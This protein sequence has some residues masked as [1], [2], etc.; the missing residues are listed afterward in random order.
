MTVK[1]YT[2]TPLPYEYDALEPVISKRQLEIHHDLHHASYVNNTN[3]DLE[4]LEKFR[5][6]DDSIQLKGLLKDLS[7]NLNGVIFHDIFWQS[8]R[9]PQE[10]NEPEGE[11]R[12]N[13]ERN[14]GSFETFK[15]EFSQAAVSVEGSG[16]VVLWKNFENDLLIGQVEKHNLL[17][18]NDWEPILVL[19]VWEHAYYLDYQ[20]RRQEFVERWWQ[21]VNWK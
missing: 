8:M 21:L 20:N 11:V 3:Q 1:N 12:E 7:F 6:G 19:D 18:L 15:K 16:W 10:N 4:K 13:L 14:F 9:P 2:L 17:A 5:N